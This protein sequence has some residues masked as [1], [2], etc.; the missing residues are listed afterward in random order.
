MKLYFHAVGEGLLNQFL[1]LFNGYQLHLHCKQSKCLYLRAV[2][3]LKI[4]YITFAQILE[5]IV[6]S[7]KTR[8]KDV[9]LNN[10]RGTSRLVTFI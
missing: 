2:D 10:I 5:E 9:I 3:N 6:L 1:E 8:I 4:K 7:T